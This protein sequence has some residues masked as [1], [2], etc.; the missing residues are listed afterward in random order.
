MEGIVFTPRKPRKS[1][2][3]DP[4]DNGDLVDE[5]VEEMKYKA[6]NLERDKRKL[7]LLR[8]LEEDRNKKPK[9]KKHKKKRTRESAG[10]NW[11]DADACIKPV[12]EAAPVVVDSE[13]IDREVRMGLRDPVSKRPFGLFDPKKSSVEELLV[14]PLPNS[15]SP[16]VERMS[17]VECNKMA[18]KAMRAKITGDVKLHDELM[19]RVNQNM[20]PQQVQVVSKTV[21]SK[22]SLPANMNNED[23]QYLRQMEKISPSMDESF[24]RNLF[25]RGALKTS[26]H[27]ERSGS[28]EIDDT[29]MVKLNQMYDTKHTSKNIDSTNSD[30][31]ML[32]KGDKRNILFIGKHL[33]IVLSRKPLA[34]G[35][36]T[37]VP[38]HSVPS[39]IQSERDTQEELLL[40]KIRLEK[41]FLEKHKKSLVYVETVLD[42]RRCTKIECV[43]LTEG[44]AEML[45]MVFKDTF[46]GSG[47]QWEAQSKKLISTSRKHPIP[48]PAEFPYL[49]VEWGGG[50]YESAG[51][52]HVVQDV[53]K[54]NYEFLVNSLRTG[55][56]EEETKCTSPGMKKDLAMEFN[57]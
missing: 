13:S 33:F 7:E 46:L 26:F 40:F 5:A 19:N 17:L 27:S 57:L 12:V 22:P 23:I 45:P 6:R 53:S 44:E 48:I 18:A 15:S 30:E 42:F 37:I 24:A 41:F 8:I 21:L 55:I 28:N 52:A 3:E 9:K 25:K 32:D 54:Y 56:L 49:H 36:C 34:D 51:Y 47:D 14:E 43:P 50:G 20:E 1:H 29:D 11:L 2:E 4:I 16:I 31:Q 35:H 38:I 39:V 10:L